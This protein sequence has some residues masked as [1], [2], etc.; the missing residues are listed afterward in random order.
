MSKNTRNTITV[1]GDTAYIEIV[2]RDKTKYIAVIDSDDILKVKDLPWH[3]TSKNYVVTI[4]RS[5]G[6]T[7]NIYLHQIILGLTPGQGYNQ[8][9]DHI[10]GDHFD[11]RSSNLRVATPSQNMANRKLAPNTTGYKG[12]AKSRD[13]YTSR[14]TVAGK[15]IHLGTFDS[16]IEAAKAY[17]IAALIHYGEYANTNF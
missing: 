15:F 4:S 14:I 7:V 11:N 10:S 1:I 5:T 13:K 12:V 3:L 16:A 9:A 2:K 8:Q 17:D 6:K